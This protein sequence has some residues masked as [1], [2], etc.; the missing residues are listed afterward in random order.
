MPS[1]VNRI[2]LIGLLSVS[3]LTAMEA[4]DVP[5]S[6]EDKPLAD[7]LNLKLVVHRVSPAYPVEA[8]R[9]RLQGRG[10]LFGQVDFKTGVVTLV[11]ME[12]STGWKVLDDAALSAF[13]QWR[14]KPGTTRKFRVPITYTMSAGRW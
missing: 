1:R 10:I 7:A 6:S 8:R 9:S 13:R 12:K 3:W 2:A 11:V 4:R 14:F 5:S